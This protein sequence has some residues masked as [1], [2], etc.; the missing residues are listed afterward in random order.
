MG[1]R[2]IEWN[3]TFLTDVFNWAERSRNGR[4]RLLLDRNPLKGLRK[5]TEPP[6]VVLSE[7]EYQAFLSVSR[8]VGWRFHVAP[9][10]PV[11]VHETGDSQPQ[12]G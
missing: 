9:V 1:N 8:Q 12:V 4:G 5:P 3:L 7:Q 10:L 11:P 6:R 2:T